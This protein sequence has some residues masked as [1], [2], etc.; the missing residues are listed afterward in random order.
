MKGVKGVEWSGVEWSRVEQ[1][2]HSTSL[3]GR[4][5]GL[6]GRDARTLLN[7]PITRGSEGSVLEEEEE[8]E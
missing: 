2:V 1:H 7:R 3:G 8:E 4:C 6:C 5:G